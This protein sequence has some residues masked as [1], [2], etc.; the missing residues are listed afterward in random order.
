V[1]TLPWAHVTI[2][3]GLPHPVAPSGLDDVGTARAVVAVDRHGTFAVAAWDE[4]ASGIML[5]D[6]G[7]RAP[8]FAEP[9]LRGVTRTRPGDPR[10]ASAPVAFVGDD[11][12]IEVAFAAFGAR[13]AYDVLRDAMRSLVWAERIEAHGEAR[14]VAAS[15]ADGNASVFR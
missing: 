12:G 7:L 13:D 9:V 15:H 11:T 4:G 2:D 1:V 6:C 8:F 14:L 3:D 5:Q 10:P